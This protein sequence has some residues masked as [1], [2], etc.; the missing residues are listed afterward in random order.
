MATLSAKR[1]P[2]TAAAPRPCAVEVASRTSCHLR[3]RCLAASASAKGSAPAPLLGGEC[4]Q[5]SPDIGE[6]L[7]VK[8]VDLGWQRPIQFLQRIPH[9]QRGHDFPDVLDGGLRRGVLGKR[10]PRAPDPVVAVEA[11]FERFEHF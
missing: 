6:H 9:A 11:A 1:D 10:A 7:A 2:A 3:F 4:I 5:K 8:F